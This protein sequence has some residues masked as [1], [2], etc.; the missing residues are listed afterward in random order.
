MTDPVAEAQ[1]ILKALGLPAAQHNRMAALVLLALARVS[2]DVPWSQATSTSL[3]IRIGIMDYIRNTLGVAYAENTRETVRRGVLHQ[4]EEAG[5]VARNIDDPARPT[6]SKD[7]NYTLT[8]EALDVV[9]AYGGADFLQKT[10][11]FKRLQG[12]LAEKYARAR[13]LERV[14]VQVNGR[15]LALSPG[16]HNQLERAIV[17]DFG[18]Y[19]ARGSLLLYL[20]DT[21]NKD[22]HVD[23]EGLESL[24]FDFS[25]HDKLPDVVLYDPN[26]GWLYLVEAVTSH[27]PMNAKRVEELRKLFGQARAGLIFVSAFPDR[28]EYRRHQA[29]IDWETEVWIAD[30]PTHLIHYN[31][32]RFL[33]PY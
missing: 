3:T 6:N 5:L 4:F 27:G 11:D 16:P 7:N 23:R 19:H 26:M 12:S 17:E 13:D 24:G 31:G 15:T 9:C 22:V 30:E 29:D 8:R 28:A 1:Q 21:A 33:G 10:D 32:D 2:Q 20:G 18:E 14:P 25:E